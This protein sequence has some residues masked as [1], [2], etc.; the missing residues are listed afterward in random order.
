VKTAVRGAYLNVLVNAKDLQD[1][2]FA[3]TI[4]SKA[5]AI[6]EENH[7]RADALVA[8]VEQQIS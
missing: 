5:K 3:Q 2:T 1:K 7:K 6:L 4:I 8:K